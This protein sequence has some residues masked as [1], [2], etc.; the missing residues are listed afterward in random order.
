MSIDP[1]QLLKLAKDRHG[2][3]GVTLGWPM[4][5]N[6]VDELRRLRKQVHNGR[7]KYSAMV[8]Q[9]QELDIRTSQVS[10]KLRESEQREKALAAHV[11]RIVTAWNADDDA[12]ELFTDEWIDHM[13]DVIEDAPQTSLARRDA[14]LLDRLARALNEDHFEYDAI[15]PDAAANWLH[16]QADELRRKS[17]EAPCSS[18]SESASPS[19]SC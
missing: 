5:I 13:G 14:A 17:E 7:D 8:E 12:R 19:A 10:A 18:T 1:E 11:E 15:A 3:A 9:C 2:P 4:V 16:D 6:I